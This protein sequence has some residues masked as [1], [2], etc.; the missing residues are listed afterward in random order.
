MFLLYLCDRIDVRTELGAD[1]AQDFDFLGSD[2]CEQLF[3]HLV[4]NGD[5][6]VDDCIG[7]RRNAEG[8]VSAVVLILL[9]AQISQFAELIHRLG[10]MPL[11]DE[12][13]SGNIT[14][15]CFRKTL[16]KHQ[17]F[18]F[19]LS[20]TV[21]FSRTDKFALDQLFHF[22]AAQN[23]IDVFFDHK[24]THFF[25]LEVNSLI[26]N[27]FNYKQCICE[28]QRASLKPSIEFSRY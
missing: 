21:L 10:Y 12:H 18:D 13:L 16:Q 2:A 27:I 14:G 23:N 1:F 26:L 6:F 7:Q 25:S 4:S 3:C 11:I 5:A 24:F 28:C 17:Y 22:S 19:Y 20:Y 8:N 9:R 15:V